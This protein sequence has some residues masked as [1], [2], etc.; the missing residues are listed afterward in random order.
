[1]Q[2]STTSSSIWRALS[3]SLSSLV[4]KRPERLLLPTINAFHR[5]RPWAVAAREHVNRSAFRVLAVILP[6]L[7]FK[8]EAARW[9][10]SG[11]KGQAGLGWSYEPGARRPAR[12][13]FGD[14]RRRAN[15]LP[16]IPLHAQ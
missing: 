3:A 10:P 6:S 12:Q 7:G 1:M 14:L 4:A 9:E 15:P 16:S 11:F 13:V 8:N 2:E 5:S